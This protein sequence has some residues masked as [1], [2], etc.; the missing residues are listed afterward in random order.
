[1]TDIVKRA[2]LPADFVYED[3]GKPSHDNRNHEGAASHKRRDLAT[4]DSL[5]SI[6]EDYSNIKHVRQGREQCQGLKGMKRE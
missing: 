3:D 5:Q 4:R 2:I 1:M 6:L